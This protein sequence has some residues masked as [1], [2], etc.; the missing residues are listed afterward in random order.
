MAVHCPAATWACC[1]GSVSSALV[2]CF[3]LPLPQQLQ[4]LVMGP[5]P[6]KTCFPIQFQLRGV[7]QQAHFHSRVTGIKKDLRKE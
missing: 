1:Q 2:S 3:G 5:V 7:S 6:S 4:P